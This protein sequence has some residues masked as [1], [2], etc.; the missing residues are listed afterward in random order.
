MFFLRLLLCKHGKGLIQR[1]CPGIFF[2]KVPVDPPENIHL[3]IDIQTV[4]GGDP[5]LLLAMG[6]HTYKHLKDKLCKQEAQ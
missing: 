6:E 4:T 1:S 5:A 3:D 2:F